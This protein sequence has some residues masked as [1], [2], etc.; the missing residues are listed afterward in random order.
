MKRTLLPSISIKAA[1][2]IRD[3]D[4]VL[5]YIKLGV[6]RIGTSNSVEILKE[7]S[8]KND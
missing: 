4:T 2:G 5:N 8:L 7:Y 6:S 1:G 3:L